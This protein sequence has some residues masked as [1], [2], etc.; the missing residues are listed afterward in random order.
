MARWLSK[1]LEW[2]VNYRALNNAINYFRAR[3]NNKEED[4]RY[5]DFRDLYYEQSLIYHEIMKKKME[6][7]ILS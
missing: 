6:N 3:D 4:Q 1:L 5:L 2:E 7:L